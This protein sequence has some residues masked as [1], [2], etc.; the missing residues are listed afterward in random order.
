MN[1][2]DAKGARTTSTNLNAWISPW[3]GL[4]GAQSTL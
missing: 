2:D 4:E 1:D 3:G